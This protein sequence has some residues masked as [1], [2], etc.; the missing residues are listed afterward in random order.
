MN[1]VFLFTSLIGLVQ[2]AE[3][4]TNCTNENS[5]NTLLMF[6]MT[7]VVCLIFTREGNRLQIPS[8]RRYGLHSGNES[9]MEEEEYDDEEEFDDEEDE[10]DEEDDEEE[11]DD[12]ED[13]DTEE[14]YEGAE[15]EEEDKTRSSLRL[16]KK[17]M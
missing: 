10:D 17:N 8:T 15:E 11:F 9:E 3:K 1:T 6:F 2:A 7:I 4:Q 14:E 5:D 12:E 16:R 13:E